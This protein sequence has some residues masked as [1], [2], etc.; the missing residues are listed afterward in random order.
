MSTF[1][2]NYK[3]SLLTAF[4]VL[5]LSF[6]SSSEI[7][8]NKLWDFKGLDKI[9]HLGMYSALTFVLFFERNKN[10]Q[11]INKK[12][13]NRKN[14]FPILFIIAAGAIIE[15]VQPVWANR[16]R[17]LMDFLANTTGVFAGFYFYVWLRHQLKR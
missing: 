10:Q 17:E 1:L 5:T 11:T 14:V 2:I 13:F 4:I 6:I 8:S 9:A 3:F 7:P 16:S 15:L 12:P